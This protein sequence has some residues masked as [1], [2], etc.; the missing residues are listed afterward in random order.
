MRT[1]G[2]RTAPQVNNAVRFQ[3]DSGTVASAPSVS[4][5]SEN[6]AA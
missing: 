5:A 2:L 4:T 1:Q 3:I 6:S